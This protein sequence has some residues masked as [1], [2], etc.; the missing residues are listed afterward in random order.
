M[1]FVILSPLCGAQTSIIS[2]AGYF[3]DND[4]YQH[5]IV[6]TDDCRLHETYFNQKGNFHDEL[7][8]YGPI[9]SQSS[10]YSED[11]GMQHVL[12]AKADGTIRDVNFSAG[13][14]V[15]LRAPLITVPTVIS[16][17]GFYAANDK[18]RILLIGSNDGTIREVFYD[19]ANVVHNGEVIATIPGLTMLT[20]FYTPDDQMRHAI[21]A[22]RTGDIIEV[23]YSSATGVH[24]TH[25]ALANLGPVTAVAGFYA[26]DDQMRHAIVATSNGDIHEIF[27]NTA[28]PPKISQP[29]LANFP[30]IRGIGA[31]YTAS[32][33]NR[34][35]IVGLA[36]GQVRE[37][38]YNPNTGKGDNL[39]WQLPTTSASAVDVSTNATNGI[40]VVDPAASGLTQQ[41]AGNQAALYAVT[42]DAG[43]AK[44]VNGGPWKRLS[45]SPRYAYSITVDPNNN[46][47]VAVG[48]RASDLAN[49]STL[50]QSYLTG[51]WE[52]LDA[53]QTWKLAYIPL[54]E[55]NCLPGA[56]PALTFTPKSSLVIATS[57]GIGWRSATGASFQ[58]VANTVVLGQITS[59]VASETKVWARTQSQLLISVDDGQTWTIKPIPAAF[60]FP[61]RGDANSLAA[62]DGA[63]YMTC[64]KVAQP[65]CGNFDKLLI[66][67][68]GTDQFALQPDLYDSTGKIPQMGCDGTGLGGSRF[69]RSFQVEGNR[70]IHPQSFLF[71]GSGQEVYEATTINPDFTIAG[72]TRPLGATCGGCTNQDRVHSDLWDFLLSPDRSTE[73]ASDDGGVYKRTTANG[74]TWTA[75]TQ[76]DSGLH[77]HHVHTLTAMRSEPSGRGNL[78]Y[79]TSDNGGW[80]W[81]GATGW[82]GEGDVGD[83]NWTIGDAGNATV[84]IVARNATDAEIVSFGTNLPNGLQLQPITIS[85]DLPA[86]GPVDFNVIQSL[87]GDIRDP[88]S[89]D[90]VMLANLPLHYEDSS[91]ST[92]TVPGALGNP[93]PA[94]SLNLVLLRNTNLVANPDINISQGAGWS[95]IAS[96]LPAGT[97]K[98]WVSGGHAK[99]TFFV[100]AVQSAAGHLFKGTSN[101]AS[102]TEVTVPGNMLAGSATYGPVFVNPYNPLQ[103]YVLTDGGVRV[104]QDGGQTF[105]LDSVLTNLI[106]A[107][108]IYPLTGK[109]SGGD[110]FGVRIAT[111]AVLLGT[112]ADMDFRRDD[113]R[114]AVAASAFSGAMFK[115]KAGKWHDLTPL[116]QKPL[117]SVSSVRIDCDAIY[118]STEGGGTTQISNYENLP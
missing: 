23:F 117:S 50:N 116:L 92:H 65:P 13:A 105:V 110:S 64:C 114:L 86:D 59:V 71:Y 85:Y 9:I 6:G 63:A 87:W 98:F 112:L 72:W 101:L 30:G 42:L 32:D 77:T 51:V 56:V 16:V 49:P 47:H 66:Y 70:I 34:H 74:S 69:V 17:A 48:E 104:S 88:L 75:W 78:I 99:P 96:N 67:N 81:N 11:D 94:G 8:C 46:A 19:K 100:Y 113:P 35:V 18:M 20:G 52:S 102:W 7:G 61:S 53:G 60:T 21:V 40:Q 93:P 91:Q 33:N 25:P 28:T 45:N 57:C 89:M 80:S 79:A 109:F 31:Y 95:I 36:T 26:A 82:Q 97:A 55:P 115:D 15:L 5:A 58:L 3:S 4:S 10:F 43:V 12:I 103:I 76:Q 24:V 73:W 62:F 54:T 44:S 29:A 106:T 2:V 37:I 41:L 83:A 1:L 68:A 107:N 118:V 111:R 90:A 108:G 27:Y 39:R 84:A 22:T 38:P 14:G